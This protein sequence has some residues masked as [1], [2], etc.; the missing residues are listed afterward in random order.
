MKSI[1]EELLDEVVRRLAAEFSPDQIIVFGS[2]A[3]GMPSKDSDLDLLVIVPQSD[4]RSTQRSVRAHRCLRGLAVPMDVLV[5]TLGEMDRFGSVPASL[6]AE[7]LNRGRIIYGRGAIRNWSGAGSPRRGMTFPRPGCSEGV[8]RRSLMLPS[9]GMTPCPKVAERATALRLLNVSR[10]SQLRI[11]AMATVSLAKTEHSIDGQRFVWYGIG[12]EGYQALLGL[13]GDRPIRLT[14]DRGNLEIMSPLA[15]HERCKYLLGRI[16]DEITMGLDIPVVAA[17][18]TTFKRQDV[19]RG[20]E[21]DQC[22]YFENAGRIQDLGH[23]R[24]DVDP[25]PDLAIEMDITRSCLNRLGIYAA[26]RIPEVWRFDGE[27]IFVL[28]LQADGTYATADASGVLPFLPMA[29][30]A[31]FLREYDQN[32]DT[33]W[34]RAVRAWVREDL[35][36]RGN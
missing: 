5:K 28:K 24:L 4:S 32:N 30:V 21:P 31:R 36:P 3:W 29:D 19:D 10:F 33:R 9:T 13:V 12:W 34:G 26:L 1:P 18:S 23:I 17:A 15:I 27:D 8:N 11:R 35:V 16:I 6:E 7:I 22:Y 2:H 14:Y 20:L 25:P